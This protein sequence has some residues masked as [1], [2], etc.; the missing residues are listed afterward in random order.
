L[1]RAIRPTAPLPRRF[2]RRCARFR[3]ADGP[4]GAVKAQKPAKNARFAPESRPVCV[5]LSDESHG[6]IAMANHFFRPVSLCVCLLL[7]L[8]GSVPAAAQSSITIAWDP[9]PEPDV[10]GYVLSWGTTP[11][12]YPNSA[13]VGN[14]TQWTVT[15]LDPNQRYLFS[16]QA[17][18]DANSSLSDRSS[19]V[20]NNGVVV[21]SGRPVPDQRPSVFWYNSTT[22]Q[23]R[24]WVMGGASVLDSHAVT[25][26]GVADT[27]WKVVATGD[28]NGDGHA[29][30]LWRHDTEGW[31]AVWLLRYQD[32]IGTEYLSINRQLDPRWKV[33]AIGDINGDGFGDIIW[34]HD[35]GWLAV[36]QMRGTQVVWT[37]F[38]DTP[39]VADPRWK[40]VAATDLNGDR[41]ADLIWREQT[42]GWIAAWFLQ[43]T[44]VIWTTYLS[45]NRVADM[46]WELSAA[47]QVDG[48]GLPA[49]IWRHRTEGTVALWFM[50]GATVVA[51][52]YA[53]PELV[54]DPAWHVV[55]GR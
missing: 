51:T 52:S 14:R 30:I 53:D 15:G 50:S 25:I 4:P 42:E 45:Q 32:V 28:L 13:D 44:K 36:W 17:Y 2:P 11:G 29:D 55:G 16:V 47:G 12:N 8:L 5:L 21:L 41:R 3:N 9:N 54:S 38:L 10:T 20:S 1:A 34:Q 43:G 27:H 24:T 39:R 35:D 18:F 40:I 23:V 46:N 31:L 37:T 26:D 49:L 6:I 33:A 48:S 7:L 22:G 19:A